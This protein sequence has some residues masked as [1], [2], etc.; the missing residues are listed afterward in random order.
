MVLL[1][2]VVFMV[3]L[4]ENLLGLWNHTDVVDKKIGDFKLTLREI[5]DVLGDQILDHHTDELE[6]LLVRAV[7]AVDVIVQL[8]DGVVEEFMK[9]HRLFDL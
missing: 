5:D 3:Y 1:L 9:Q 6:Y 7:L 4:K 2:A 8:N